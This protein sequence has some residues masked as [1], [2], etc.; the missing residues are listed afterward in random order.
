MIFEDDETLQMYVEESLEHLSDIEN[1]LLAVEQGGADINEE[2]VNKVFR[3]AH[4][5]KGGAGFM[6]LTTIKE[7]SHK[8]ENILGMVRSREIVPDPDIVSVLLKA[9]DKLRDLINNIEK[10]NDID[11]KSYLDALLAITTD[12]LPENKKDSAQQFIDIFLPD[13]RIVF[14]VSKLDIDLA[15]KEGKYVYLVEYDLLH[16]IQQKGKTPMGVITVLQHSGVI[17]E[18]KIDVEKVGTLDITSPYKI[19]FYIL[20]ASII[21]PEIISTLFDIDEK[22]VHTLTEDI[23]FSFPKKEIVSP[24][25]E[26]EK[27]VTDNTKKGAINP[28]N[29]LH[30]VTEKKEEFKKQIIDTFVEE[31][32]IFQDDSINDATDDVPDKQVSPIDPR[33]A[34]AQ[35]S[36]RVN[37]SILDA[38]MTLAGELVLSR[39]QLLQGITASNT[40]AIEI[41]SQ[42]IDM[43]TSELQEAIMRTRMQPIGNVFNKF[44]RVVRDLARDLG[45][46]VNIVI[47]GKEVELDKTI[48]EAISDPLTHLVR[49]SVDHGIET[50]DVRE[51]I[52]KSP[53]GTVKLKAFHEAGQV[54]IEIEDDGKGLDANKIAASAVKKGVAIE[55]QAA[56]MSEKEKQALI[57]LPG[58]STAEKVTDVSGRGVGMDVVKTNLDRLGGTVDIDSKVGRGTIVRIKLP[59]TLAIIPCQIISV[60]NERYAIPQVNLDELLRI[61]ASQV[62]D[63]IEKVGDAEVVRLRGNLLPL[64]NLSDVLSIRQKYVELEDGKKLIDRRKNLSDRRGKRGENENLFQEEGNK[65][66]QEPSLPRRQVD[67]RF[68][69]NSAINIAVVSAG[70]FKYGLVV[71]QLRDSEEIVVK[72]LGRHLKGCS[73]YIGAT[74]MGDGKVALILDVASLAKMAEL[75][76]VI[77]TEKGSISDRDKLELQKASK[78]RASWLL[79]R[80]AEDEQFAVPLGLVERIERIKVSEIEQ[81]GGKKVIQCRGGTLPLYALSEVAKV[82][83][84]NEKKQLEVIV[85]TLANREV[86]LLATPPIDA[87]DV[88]ITIDS[89]TLKQS[90]IMGSAIINNRTTLLV[91]IYEFVRILNPDW[92]KNQK[93]TRKEEQKKA[94]ILFAEDSAFFREQVKN[95]FIDHGFEVIEAE[96]GAEAWELLQQHHDSIDI[97]VTDLEMPNMNGFQLTQKIR[98]NKQFAHFPVIALTSLAGDEDKAK[99]KSVG[100]DDYQIKLDRENVLNSVIK[101]IS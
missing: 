85:F 29:L 12:S 97:V 90:G 21:E 93:F 8:V 59:L 30:D 46:Q 98:E 74:I 55:Q 4:S 83:P 64:L 67:R 35:T 33:Q 62:K 6:G 99:G 20:Y 3:A 53:I 2:L 32:S 80:N 76:S 27:L 91:D 34:K 92:F 68:H 38:L 31:T 37:V 56:M 19:P 42:R 26:I 40:R 13:G 24:K 23:I 88:S 18:S 96:D 61:P 52:K 16:D 84:I 100:I 28:L 71:D 66:Q 39:N 15:F 48:I 49:N 43:V 22:Y 45:K 1:D 75:S 54:N 11:V 58:F 82:K 41:A 14:K 81:V 51:R 89:F 94:T 9:F 78:D 86:G 73:G 65:S 77:G 44:P 63:R 72:P 36:L 10:S 5:I 79:F 69:A 25:E 70:T 57:F 47:E 7:L 50:P 17:I 101:H 95:F 60:G 87:V